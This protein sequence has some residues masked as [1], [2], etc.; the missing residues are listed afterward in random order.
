MNINTTHTDTNKLI[1]ISTG[2][3]PEFSGTFDCIRKTI[4]KDGVKGLYKGMAAPIYGVTPMYALC[5]LGYG[6]GQGV[7]CKEDT[8]KV[9]IL[10][11]MYII[12]QNK[13]NKTKRKPSK[14]TK[15]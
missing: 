6:V 14:K 13:Q 9:N 11:I 8:Y 12:K 10:L 7:F 1:H 15:C 4:A 3:K 5:F 2:K